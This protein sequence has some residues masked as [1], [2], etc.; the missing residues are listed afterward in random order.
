MTRIVF[1]FIMLCIFFSCSSEPKIPEGVLEKEKM[2]EVMV[3]F[4]ITEASV[5]YQQNHQ[6]D[7][8]FYTNYY[9]ENVLKKHGISRDDFRKS[10]DYYKS[11]P[12][13]LDNMYGEVLSRLSGL[14][15]DKKK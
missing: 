9:Y 13:E 10:I 15:E 4:Q 7:I 14:Q 5:L 8:K 1:G 12:E 3:D 2:I 6:K 11:Y